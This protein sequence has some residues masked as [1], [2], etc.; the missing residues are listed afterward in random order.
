[1]TDNNLV[2]LD[3]IERFG[4]PPVAKPMAIFAA[5]SLAGSNAPPRLFHVDGLI[6]ARTVTLLGGDGATGKSLLALQLAVATPLRST[7]LGM[8]VAG[9]RSLFLTAEDDKDEV[10]RRLEDIAFHAGAK[11]EDLHDLHIVS[12]AG[13]DALLAVTGRGNVLTPTPRFAELKAAIG[14]LEP[15]LVVL[16]TLADLFGGDEIS[17]VHARQFVGMLRGLAIQHDTTVLLLA[18]PSLSGMSSGAGT[19]GSTAWSNSVRSRLYLERVKDE[20]GIETDPDARVMRT[21]KAN[22]SPI[23]G[24]YRMRWQAGVFVSTSPA[25]GAE[26]G[27]AAYAAKDN[28]DRVF[29]DMLAT[30]DAERRS[31]SSSQSVTF[32]PAVFAKDARS[33]GIGKRALTDAMNRLFAAKRIEVIESGPPSKRRTRIVVAEHEEAE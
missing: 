21:M 9:G 25:P 13:E 29:L 18:H 28:A 8:P 5:S 10:H 16:D 30:Y 22:Y 17:R 31:V 1:M 3:Q 32:A 20:G 4:K 11:I 26:S 27:L 19:S 23:G 14:D 6:P 24:E 7:W 33:Q 12:L 2:D 15:A